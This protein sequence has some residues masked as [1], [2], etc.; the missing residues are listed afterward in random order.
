MMLAGKKILIGVSGSIAAYKS[1]HLVRLLIKAGAEVRVIMTPAATSFITPL[2]LETLSKQAVLTDLANQSTW[3]N[4]VMLGRWADIFLIAPASVNTIGR[5]SQGLCDNLLLAVYLSATCPVWV[6]P[7]MDEDMWQHPSLQR[8]LESLRSFGN[9]I[10]PVE[11]GE[12]ASGLVGAGRMAEPETLIDRLHHY[13]LQKAAKPQGA[14][15]G[16]KV[17]VT[18]G[19]TREAIDPVRFISNHSSGKMGIA[20][21][22]ALAEQGAEVDLI[23]GPTKLQTQHPHITVVPVETA[24]QMYEACAI[25]APHSD[26]WVMAA[27]VADYRP[28]EVASQKVKKKDSELA[29]ALERTTDIAGTLG[30]TKRPDQ[31][32]IGFSLET[33]DEI[34]FAQ[35]KLQKKNMDLIVLNSLQ[36]PGAGFHHDTNKVTLLR[37]DGQQKSLPLEQKTWVAQQIVE[38]IITLQHEV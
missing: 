26:I 1:A 37:K 32:H 35:E 28:K 15:T 7:A 22:E 8:N 24:A 12:L 11:S 19:P 29:I 21:A 27:A 14:L 20:L 23:L 18:A 5:M 2:T 4:H 13:F 6:A 16:K 3:S 36:D 33:H 10:I 9:E 17:F 30:A 25:R 31:L 34:H 38:E